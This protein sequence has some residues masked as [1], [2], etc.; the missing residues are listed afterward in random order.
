[1]H[2]YICPLVWIS[3]KTE[4]ILVILEA[5]MSKFTFRHQHEDVNLD[6][7]ERNDGDFFYLMK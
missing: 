6:F 1:M 3:K 5:Q 7:L 4:G 2:Q